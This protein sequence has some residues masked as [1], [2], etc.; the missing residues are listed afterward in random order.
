[1]WSWGPQWHKEVPGSEGF[2]IGDLVGM[3]GT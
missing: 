2:E 3:S 1:M